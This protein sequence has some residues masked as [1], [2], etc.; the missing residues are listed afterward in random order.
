[1]QGLVPSEPPFSSSRA[2]EGYYA[3]RRENDANRESIMFVTS[4]LKSVLKEVGVQGSG[5]LG[6]GGAARLPW[7]PPLP[8]LFSHWDPCSGPRSNR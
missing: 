2:T 8:F 3:V 6:S 1:M 7:A 5:Q 4:S